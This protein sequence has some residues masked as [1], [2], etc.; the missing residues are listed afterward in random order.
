MIQLKVKG[1]M[2]GFDT[3]IRTQSE[4]DSCKHI[5]LTNGSK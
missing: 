2:S 3:R 5:V 4:V 1:V